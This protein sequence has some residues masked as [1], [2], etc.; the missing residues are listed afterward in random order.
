MSLT[1]LCI[2][3]YFS[4]FKAAAKYGVSYKSVQLDNKSFDP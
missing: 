3:K 1:N 2:R 4:T